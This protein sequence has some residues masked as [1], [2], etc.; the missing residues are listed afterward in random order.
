M[1]HAGDLTLHTAHQPWNKLSHG[2]EKTRYLT[3][4][5]SVACIWLDSDKISSNYLILRKVQLYR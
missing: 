5:V 2:L 4:D 1:M 3:N